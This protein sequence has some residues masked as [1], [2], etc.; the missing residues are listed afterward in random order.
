MPKY[1]NTITQ[2]VITTTC[3][4]AGGNWEEVDEPAKETKIP[5]EDN[6]EDVE[7]DDFEDAEDIEPEETVIATPPKT[8]SKNTGKTASGKS[9]SRT[10]KKS[11]GK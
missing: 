8:A 4:I 1:R 5:V 3:V 11:G 9:T 10:I 2:A 6:F 7:K